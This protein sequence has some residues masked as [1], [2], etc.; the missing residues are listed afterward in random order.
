MKVKFGT[1]RR[2]INPELP[3]SLAGYFNRRPWNE[4]L[5]DLEVRAVVFREGGDYSA[6]IQFDVLSINYFL[7]T[8]VFDAVKAA[9]IKDFSSKNLLICA[10]H[11]HTAPDCFGD[12]NSAEYRRFIAKKAAEALKDA[13]G[14]LRKGELFNAMAQDARFQFNRR[15]WMKNGTVVTNP[16]KLNPDILRPEGDIDPQIPILAVKTEAGIELLMTS[17]VN[18]TDTIGGCGVSADWPG[19]MRRKLE[20]QMAPGAMLLHLIGASGNINHFDVSTDMDQTCYAEPKRIGE[21]Y[22]ETV[23]AAL[24][25]L[26]PVPGKKIRMT[27]RK[28]KTSPRELDPAEVA[29]ARETVARFPDVDI[30]K[31]GSEIDLTSEDLAKGA[32]FALKYFAVKLLELVDEP[33][34]PNFLLTKLEFGD[35][36]VLASLPSEP[37]VEIGLTVRRAI[38]RDKFCMITSHGNYNG[39]KQLAGGYIPNAW[40]YGRGGYET[41]P[42]SSA[43]G[44]ETSDALIE[45]WRKLAKK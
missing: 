37:F 22:A 43:Y 5:D 29:A 23:S 24:K 10:T 18:H 45:N 19:F 41:T 8:E 36:V 13:L 28:V 25:D 2:C 4:V 14:S 30:S 32:P 40:N 26:Q 38:F 35:S 16:G 33:K 15:Y 12:P 34:T 6:I 1:G 17:I 9:G 3:I 20:P 11:T 42:R 39:G 31:V 21:G 27:T 7:Y 44:M